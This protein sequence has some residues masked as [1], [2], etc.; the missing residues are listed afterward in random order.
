MKY[1]IINFLV[2][3]LLLGCKYNG[4]P[5]LNQSF[6][7]NDKNPFGTYV[8]KELLTQSFP[9][10]D[11]KEIQYLKGIEDFN[12]SVYFSVSQKFY[13]I[14]FQLNELKDFVSKG[15]IA[16]ISA[17]KIDSEILKLSESDLGLKGF[18]IDMNPGFINTY[19]SLNEAG[20][21]GLRYNYFFSPF[22]KAFNKVADIKSI[23]GFNDLNEPNFVVISYGKGKFFLHN[24]PRA[25]SNYFLLSHNNYKYLE[26]V[27]NSFEVNPHHILWGTEN[28]SMINS[29][30]ESAWDQLMKEPSLSNAI[31]I[32]LLLLIAY[33]I[34]ESR[35]KQKVIPIKEVNMNN[36]IE[37]S[38]VLS[39]LYLSKKDNKNIALKMIS[40]FNEFCRN[41]FF[42][43]DNVS[44]LDPVL[45]SGKTGVSIEDV[46]LLKEVTS[47]IENSETV[48]DELLI[49]L[50]TQINKFHK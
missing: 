14:D 17:Y 47:V 24:D 41:K 30:K 26:G 45:F 38:E 16:F 28:K 7:H 40:Y 4:L 2:C 43:K 29:G 13:L 11:V 46:R 8:T 39:N 49:S 42:I 34:F 3:V 21:P 5:P 27:I 22:D 10:A 48:D 50:Q 15:N 19:V 12:E 9:E 18:N 36:S 6:S 23:K 31:W 33:I 37:F 35:R 20:K 1:F 44:N 32:I 25:F